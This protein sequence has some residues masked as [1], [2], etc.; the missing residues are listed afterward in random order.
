ML[1][2][3]AVLPNMPHSDSNINSD[4]RFQMLQATAFSR[5]TADPRSNYHLDP[6]VLKT[7]IDHASDASLYDIQHGSDIPMID[8]QDEI[9]PNLHSEA[10]TYEPNESFQPFGNQPTAPVIGFEAQP[11]DPNVGF[12]AVFNQSASPIKGHW[13]QLVDP[14][15]DWQPLEDHPGIGFETQ[16]LE[17]S[18]NF[19]EFVNPD[20]YAN[21]S[22][23][24]S[25]DTQFLPSF[26]GYTHYQNNG[27]RSSSNVFHNHPAF[28]DPTLS[29]AE[30]P[31]DLDVTEQNTQGNAFASQEPVNHQENNGFA[32]GQPMFD[33]E[34]LPLL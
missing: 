18:A 25:S 31:Y 34:D 10:Q 23:L 2:D 21:E 9:A 12:Q 3:Y 19:E 8:N 27:A 4:P 28:H 20:C 15:T 14:S 26:E 24:Q 32:Y 29:V 17:P 13:A 30:N 11:F 5:N 1:Q 7:D 22:S 33:P 6:R 16:P